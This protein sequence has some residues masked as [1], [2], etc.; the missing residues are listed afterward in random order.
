MV[1]G[2]NRGKSTRFFSSKPSRPA[3]R[4]TRLLGTWVLSCGKAVREC[5]WPLTSNSLRMNGIMPLFPVYAYMP[6]TGTTCLLYS[7]RIIK[8]KGHPKQA[9]CGPEGSRRFRLSDF[10]TFGTWRWWGCHPH[11]PG[12]LYPQEMF[13]VLI[14]TRGWVDPRA[15]VRS[16]GICHWTWRMYEGWNF[17]SG[18]YLFTTDTK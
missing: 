7:W 17:N 18:N 15:M 2:S 9:R 14:F 3:L 1:G 5:C 13:L 11:A 16:E 10:M 4:P 6:W 12:R 8:G